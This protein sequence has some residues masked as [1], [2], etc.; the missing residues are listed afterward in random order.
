MKLQ[1]VRQKQQLLKTFFFLWFAETCQLLQGFLA[2]NDRMCTTNKSKLWSLPALHPGLLCTSAQRQTT[3]QHWPHHTHNNGQ[4]S[5][6]LTTGRAHHNAV[7]RGRGES[8]SGAKTRPAAKG[9]G[10]IHKVHPGGPLMNDLG[11]FMNN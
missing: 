5:R 9:R 6:R 3:K 10:S 1:L 8:D 2:L 11:I 4:S 7:W